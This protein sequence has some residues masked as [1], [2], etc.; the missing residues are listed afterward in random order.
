[1]EKEPSWLEGGG[2]RKGQVTNVGNK[3]VRRG[4]GRGERLLDLD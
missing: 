1:M 2:R 4:R 3:L